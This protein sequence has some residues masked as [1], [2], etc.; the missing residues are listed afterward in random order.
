MGGR[1]SGYAKVEEL[2]E[3]SYGCGSCSGCNYLQRDEGFY[4]EVIEGQEPAWECPDLAEELHRE[5]VP[6]PK[7]LGFKSWV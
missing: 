5:E 2:W 7:K 1:C 6:V 4:C 3:S